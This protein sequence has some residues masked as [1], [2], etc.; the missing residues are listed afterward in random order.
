M[1]EK[2]AIRY[3]PVNV[4]NRCKTTHVVISRERVVSEGWEAIV[5]SSI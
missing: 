5:S 1:K 3:V 4:L 2:R